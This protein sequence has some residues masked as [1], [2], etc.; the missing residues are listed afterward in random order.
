[1]I[2]AIIGDIAGSA[3]E[4]DNTDDYSFPMF[5][6]RHDFTDDTICTVAVADAILKEKDFSIAMHA[7]CRKYP[8][9]MGAYGCRFME[10]VNSKDPRPYGSYGNGAAMRVSPVAWLCDTEE[11][12]R[13]LAQASAAITHNH[14][15]GIKGAKA[16]AVEIFRM[17]NSSDKSPEIY[18][19]AAK[20]F[21]GNRVFDTLPHRGVFD[22][23][24]QGCVPLSFYIAANASSFEDAVRTAVIYGGDTDTVGA[25]V[26]SLAEASFDVPNH[27]ISA[28]KLFLPDEMLEVLTEFETKRKR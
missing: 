1:M 7:W 27:L 10:W 20:E 19:N 6:S 18:I 21:Y 14:P 16:V 26:G 9:P 3:F 17:K 13:A 22:D 12:T 28:A 4:F 8:N 5:D 24:C 11:Q 2:G 25:I 23:T 15:E